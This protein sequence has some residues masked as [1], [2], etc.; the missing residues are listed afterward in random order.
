MASLFLIL[1]TIL[2]GCS[3]L[4]LEGKVDDLI[5]LAWEKTSRV[6][7]DPDTRNELRLGLI[8]DAAEKADFSW[9]KIRIGQMDPKARGLAYAML[10]WDAAN[11][12]YPGAA[13]MF[14]RAAEQDNYVKTDEETAR[15]QAYLA[16]T[17]A[18]LGRVQ[19]AQKRL[20]TILNA[21]G[22]V[23]GRALVQSARWDDQSPSILKPADEL[24]PE[25]VPEMV[26]V[27]TA[28][29]RDPEIDLTRKRQGLAFAEKNMI[30]ADPANGAQGWAQLARSAQ[31]AGLLGEAAVFARRAMDL[32]QALDPRTEQYGISLGAAAAALAR[33]GD[34]VEAKRCLEL[35]MAK[36]GVVALF[37]QPPVLMAVAEAQ[38]AMGRGEQAEQSWIKALK[39]AR[40]HHHPRARDMNVV[41]ALMSLEEAGREPT[42]EMVAIMDSISRGEGGTAALPPGFTRVEA[43]PGEEQSEGRKPSVQSNRPEAKRKKKT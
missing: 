8:R 42:L 40:S 15:I 27:L 2:T 20:A 11:Q 35:A 14:L 9:A 17:E 6:E 31:E 12:G 13:R 5:N 16:G 33:C 21:Q 29:L 18:S 38:Q 28:V 19:G 25:A 26:K 30:K 32:A 43:K 10:A 23:F 36:P 7:G 41:L 34:L 22:R 4:K 39:V 3:R 37:F 1:V 24:A